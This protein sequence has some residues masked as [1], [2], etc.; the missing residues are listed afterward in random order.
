MVNCKS[1]SHGVVKVKTV[2]LEL[3]HRPTVANFC[4]CLCAPY[5]CNAPYLLSKYKYYFFLKY[6]RTV[7]RLMNHG[8]QSIREL[9][10]FPI[11]LHFPWCP[12]HSTNPHV[13]K[14]MKLT[15]FLNS[16]QFRSIRFP[17]NPVS[18]HHY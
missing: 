8:T 7:V 13:L 16:P 6:A 3:W 12:L 1:K 10:Y 14:M 2:K 9:L 17:V 11:V 4:H 5:L 15:L 18:G